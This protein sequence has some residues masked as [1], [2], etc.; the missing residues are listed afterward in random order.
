[1]KKSSTREILN[2]VSMI[3]GIWVGYELLTKLHCG[4]TFPVM[5][6]L[7]SCASMIHHFH[8]AFICYNHILLRI[9]LLFQQG[10]AITVLCKEGEVVRLMY[11]LFLAFM[12]LLIDLAKN[13]RFGYAI[14]GMIMMILADLY[15][16]DV[17]LMC[18]TDILVFMYGN[19]T[20]SIHAHA[21]FHLVAHYIVLTISHRMCLS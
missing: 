21:V 16:V 1:M 3:P 14:N 13:K 18:L 15:G 2:A 5:Y 9:D 4:I 12:S 6:M 19:I 8:S 20:R 7:F 10:C 11:V 17:K